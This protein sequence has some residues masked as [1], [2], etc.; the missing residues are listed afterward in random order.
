MSDGKKSENKVGRD[1]VPKKRS[2]AFIEQ[3]RRQRADSRSE[4]NQNKC[5][6]CSNDSNTTITTFGRP[7]KNI[8]IIQSR[9]KK[10]R[11]RVKR[12]INKLWQT[13]SNGGDVERWREE[14][15]LNEE[16]NWIFDETNDDGESSLIERAGL[17]RYYRWWCGSVHM[18]LLNYSL[19]CNF[20][21]WELTIE[22]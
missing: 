17:G 16:R 8:I 2:E 1:E 14:I 13:Q 10:R 9:E 5:S 21:F 20:M 4:I 18:F 15:E 7:Q 6:A 11:R 3:W 12:H 19:S 22:K